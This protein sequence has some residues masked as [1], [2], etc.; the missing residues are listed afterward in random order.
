MV[1]LNS[2]QAELDRLC[3]TVPL[4]AS[5]PSPAV[6]LVSLLH[7]ELACR[8]SPDESFRHRKGQRS[9]SLGR[10]S[11]HTLRWAVS[12]PVG[13]PAQND[14]DILARDVAGVHRRRRGADSGHRSGCAEVPGRILA[15]AHWD[16]PPR[17]SPVGRS[18]IFAAAQAMSLNRVTWRSTS[19]HAVLTGSGRCS[20]P[21]RPDRPMSLP[22]ANRSHSEWPA[23]CRMSQ[24][25]RKNPPQGSAT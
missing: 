16:G 25:C 2:E 22:S 5:G 7:G 4:S 23:A 15:R 9:R 6:D 10:A 3:L 21:A 18:E 17:E 11:S 13:G 12:R 8:T 1:P 24:P 20:T 19:T 14:P